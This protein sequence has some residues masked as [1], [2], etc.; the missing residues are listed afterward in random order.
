M[1]FFL[2]STS[3]FLIVFVHYFFTESFMILVTKVNTVFFFNKK[4]NW[5][6][7]IEEIHEK[8]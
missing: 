3:I 4:H 2:I 7:K 5:S 6:P 1:L 8:H